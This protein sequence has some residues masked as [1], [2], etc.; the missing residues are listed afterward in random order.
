MRLSQPKKKVFAVCMIIGLIAIVAFVASFF[1]DVAWLGY[2]AYGALLVAFA[3]LTAS[4][5]L[6]GV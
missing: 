3:L 5:A 4:V 1:V 2:A 6:K